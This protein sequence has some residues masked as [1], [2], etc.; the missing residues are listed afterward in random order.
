[1][2]VQPVS[3]RVRR[4]LARCRNVADVR[5]LA[6]RRL[7]RSV[8]DFVDGGAE[9]EVTVARN[10]AAF[11]RRALLP[12]VLVDVGSVDLSTSVLGQPIRLPVMLAPC[13]LMR[14]VH[15][16]GDGAAARAAHR[17]G[18]IHVLSTSA[19]TS[20]EDLAAETSGPRWFQIYVWRDRRILEDL[21][22]RARANGCKALCLSVDSPVVGRR[23]RDLLHGGGD[24]PRVRPRVVVDALVHPRWL[25]GF[26]TTPAIGL[27]NV[28]P[29][30]TRNLHELGRLA[31]GQYDPT[32]S[33]NDLEWMIRRWDGPF[34]VKGV[35]HPDDAARAVE[36]GANAIVV[37]NHG[38]RQLDQVPAT[39][40]LLPAVVAA[41]GDRAEVLVDGG[42]RRGADVVKALALGARACL[43]GRPYVYGLGAGGE[44]GVGHV[45]ALLREEIARTMALV[46]CRAVRDLEPGFLLDVA[47]SAP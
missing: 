2:I 6:R 14:L 47:T 18:T 34:A 13:G 25:W 16:A 33:W 19:S 15:P 23:E 43:I 26:V 39:L 9:D 45:L 40:D 22:E 37:S 38:G 42:I 27:P 32:V 12:R 36:L 41:V 20:I 5:A 29:G 11:A 8:F 35:L 1:L 24:P 31:A 7:P 4:H 44:A 46:G 21:I 10:R 30:F 3:R 28:L 17:A